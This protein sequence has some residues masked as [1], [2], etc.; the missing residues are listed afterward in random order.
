MT[1][2]LARRPAPRC[3][4]PVLGDDVVVE[5]LRPLT[6]GAS[7]IDL[8][9]RR[10]HRRGDRPLI[11][12]TG[13]PDDIHAGM[14]LEARAQTLAAAAGAPVPHVLVADNSPAALGN[15]F[16]ICDEIAGETIA[17]RSIADST[18]PGSHGCSSNARTHWPRSTAPTLTA[19]A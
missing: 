8:G 2:E 16:L 18:T 19:S 1:D 5:N 3:S 11:L 10:R 4:H 12:R 6:G 15:P 17:R 9:L 13:P 7:R 14:E